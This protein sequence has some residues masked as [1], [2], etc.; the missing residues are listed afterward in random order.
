MGI[1]N[2]FIVIPEIIASFTF[3]PVIKAIFGEGS[4]AAPIY[5]VMT[6]G[7]CMLIAAAVCLFFVN[8]PG[9]TAIP[10]RVDEEILGM[11]ENVQ[12]SPSQAV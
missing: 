9:I 11:P 7:V 3:G 2:F 8:D 6:G 5:V 10:A 12:P 1:F 4:T